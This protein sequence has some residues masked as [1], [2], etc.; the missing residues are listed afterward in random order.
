MNR[1]IRTIIY[2]TSWDVYGFDGRYVVL[3]GLQQFV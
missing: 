3:R 1:S 2:L